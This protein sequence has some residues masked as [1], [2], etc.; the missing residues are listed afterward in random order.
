MAANESPVSPLTGVHVHS[1]L[2]PIGYNLA[3]SDLVN[4]N[5]EIRY[6]F[7][8][9]ARWC[10]HKTGI[11][12]EGHSD[13]SGMKFKFHNM[14]TFSQFEATQCNSN[15]IYTK[16]HCTNKREKSE[17]T[18]CIPPLTNCTAFTHPVSTFTE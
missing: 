7:T 16:C 13:Y 2:F 12:Q 17:F 1:F 15:S 9:S 10:Q 18:H 8:V 14:I 5:N 3:A 4:N 11:N 6:T